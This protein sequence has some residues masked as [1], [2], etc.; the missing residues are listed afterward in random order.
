MV[1]DDLPLTEVKAS[2][3]NMSSGA[4]GSVS[5]AR[6]ACAAVTS[7]LDAGATPALAGPAAIVQTCR[8]HGRPAAPELPV[9]S[10][11]TG[12]HELIVCGRN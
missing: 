1:Y 6:A 4:F 5:V 7:A 9:A 12:A 11:T 2:A 10:R 8:N 3:E